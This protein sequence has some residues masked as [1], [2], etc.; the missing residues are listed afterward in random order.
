MRLGRQAAVATAL[1]GAWIILCD[2]IL[3]PRQL[4]QTGWLAQVGGTCLTPKVLQSTS[5][6]G[7]G[8]LFD[9]VLASE[10]AVLAIADL[11]WEMA[12]TWRAHKALRLTLPRKP[13]STKGPC[14]AVPRGYPRVPRGG[15]Q[16][17]HHAK[18]A[19]QRMLAELKKR[20]PA[21]RGL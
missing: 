1:G 20:S 3:T 4:A 7:S 18:A 17:D 12:A 9:Y 5:S 15:R 21:A 14:L 10:K 8:R 13:V 6:A 2:W 19:R 16:A 11:Q